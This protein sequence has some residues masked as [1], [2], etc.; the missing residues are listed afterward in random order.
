VQNYLNM[1]EQLARQKIK[2]DGF[3]DVVNHHSSRTTQAGL[4]YMQRPEAGKRIPRGSDVVIYVS[5]GLPRREVPQLV[6]LDQTEAV[7]Q[8]ARLGLKAEPHEV[9]SSKPSGTVLAQDPPAG[10]KVEV[11]TVVRINISKG[12]QPVSVPSVVGLP[13]D[14]ASS[15][16]QGLKFRVA[17][18]F[19]ESD[20]PANT[21]I[22]QSPEANA[23]A[24]KGSVITLTVSKGPSTSTIPDVT[25]L[26]VNTAI[27]T[28]QNSGF[29]ATIQY[30]DVTDPTLDQTVLEQSPTGGGQA[31]PKT[32]VTLVVGRLSGGTDTTVTTTP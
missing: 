9:P 1:Q 16:L 19:V 23:S 31:K 3:N 15:T 26:D 17:T 5:T 24:G 2:D 20:Q 12:P 27:E 29:R 22:D 21:V 18:T 11:N 10:T 30:E 4:V 6:D 32:K 8:L 25:S 13:I 7:A 28:L 14:Q